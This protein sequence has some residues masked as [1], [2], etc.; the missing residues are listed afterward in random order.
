MGELAEDFKKFYEFLF[1][2]LEPSVLV[3]GLAV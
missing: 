2:Q 1:S 3:D